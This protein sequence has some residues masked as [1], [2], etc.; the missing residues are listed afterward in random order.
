[1][2]LVGTSFL[3]A[4]QDV[5]VEGEVRD[6]FVA[7]PGSTTFSGSATVDM[8]DGSVPLLG[9][10][11]TV[12]ATTQSL[13]LTLGPSTLPSATLVAGSITIE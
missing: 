12:T 3:G 11:F 2:V 9:V 5:I 13:L 6:G 8:G 10:P 4:P 7:G 1:M